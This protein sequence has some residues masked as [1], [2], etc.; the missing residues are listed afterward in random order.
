M[1]HWGKSEHMVPTLPDNG[2]F[3]TLSRLTNHTKLLEEFGS[4][5][6]QV[7]H[8]PKFITQQME[9]MMEDPI[10]H[11]SV[12]CFGD[13]I[14]DYTEGRTN[15]TKHPHC[16]KVKIYNSI[17]HQFLQH[18]TDN[19]NGGLAGKTSTVRQ[20]RYR[21]DGLMG[22]K[23]FG[24]LPGCSPHCRMEGTF[25]L[26]PDFDFDADY[27]ESLSFVWDALMSAWSSISVLHLPMSFIT[28]SIERIV[29]YAKS[30]AVPAHARAF[31]GDST[32]KVTFTGRC[33][34]FLVF[35]AFGVGSKEVNKM[36]H[37]DMV[38]PDDK[39]KSHVE[40][41]LRQVHKFNCNNDRA[42]LRTALLY[43]RPRF[44]SE[45]HVGIA[46]ERQLMFP[47]EHL[48]GET[49]TIHRC[50][51]FDINTLGLY[52]PAS[53]LEGFMNDVL[54]ET[55]PYQCSF[56]EGAPVVQASLSEQF[57]EL[58]SQQSI[59]DLLDFVGIGLWG[60]NGSI[61]VRWWSPNSYHRGSARVFAHATN[62]VKLL[63]SVYEKIRNKGWLGTWSQHLVGRNAGLDDDI[64]Y[65]DGRAVAL[66]GYNYQDRDE[67]EMADAETAAAEA[68]G[69]VAQVRRNML[70]LR[71]VRTFRT[72]TD[73]VRQSARVAAA[74]DEGGAG[75]SNPSESNQAR[76]NRRHRRQQRLH[77]LEQPNSRQRQVRLNN[78]QMVQSMRSRRQRQQRQSQQENRQ[79]QRRRCQ[80]H[81]EK[82]K[83]K[84]VDP[85][86]GL[87]KYF[88]GTVIGRKGN[89]W[90]IEYDDGDKEELDRCELQEGME[91]WRNQQ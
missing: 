50:R 68:G 72:Y 58:I 24:L 37:D 19:F 13:V 56:S 70:A 79:R 6:R 65:D 52:I 4:R 78:E 15:S 30:S 20:Y 77:E 67:Q 60:M 7:S 91:E 39:S 2:S 40:W 46:V 49:L 12:P 76:R 27:R 89:L 44:A 81:G 54:S 85:N 23:Y 38:H 9:W 29:S 55:S 25:T 63:Q 35:N 26:R 21:I 53:T 86:D 36:L 80:Y 18:K 66:D 69:E 51:P 59:R 45:R 73:R 22:P 33:F 11:Q 43:G 31:N 1:M 8:F 48:P 34:A 57:Q 64:D 74:E 88:E 16:S 32:N 41:F 83:K 42:T 71:R 90:M 87:E 82:T 3:V 61:C 62:I 28:A 14:I 75:S 5:P 10:I 17:Y 84:F 47:A